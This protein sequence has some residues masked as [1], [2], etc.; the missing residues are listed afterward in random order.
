MLAQECAS[1]FEVIVVDFA[2][3]EGTFD[4]CRGL[5]LR[6]LVAMKV[7]DAGQEFHLS[8]ARNCGAQIAAGRLLAFVDADVYVDPAWLEAATRAIRAGRAGLATVAPGSSCWGTCAVAA[9]LFHAVRGYDE[10]LRG[11]GAEDRDFY[12][13][14]EAKA[15]TVR[16]GG[17]LLTAIEHG[18]AERVRFQAERDI[19]VSNAGNEACLARRMGTV[20][21]QG[22]GRG[23]FVVFRGRGDALP[24]VTWRK[25]QRIVPPLRRTACANRS[26]SRLPET[27]GAKR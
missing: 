1:A 16:F 22:Y 17:G 25:R 13:R 20:N 27:S 10:E 23:E 7:L 11:W 15:R 4:W 5:G 19:L 2:C 8:R 9:E 26:L 18:N 3:P 24:P 21:P 12:C 14:A 6:K